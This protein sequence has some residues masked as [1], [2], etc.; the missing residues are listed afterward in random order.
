MALQVRPTTSRA[1]VTVS[2]TLSIVAR[3]LTLT[4]HIVDFCGFPGCMPCMHASEPEEV[5]GDFTVLVLLGL[6]VPSSLYC[7][8]Y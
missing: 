8:S 4:M 1:S 7:A 5:G 3:A 2:R 6:M